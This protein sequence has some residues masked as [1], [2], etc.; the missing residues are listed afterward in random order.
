MKKYIG[1]S[2]MVLSIVILFLG[3]ITKETKTITYNNT[4]YKSAYN[5]SASNIE[6]ITVPEFKAYEIAD[7][8]NRP[9]D[10]SNYVFLAL[11]VG[12][13]GFVITGIYLKHN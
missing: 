2:L 8:F 1:L 6:V 10:S 11:I 12:L 7:D 13:A 5:L 3:T 4:V 9:N